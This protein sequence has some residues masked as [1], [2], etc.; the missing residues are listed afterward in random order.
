MNR[1]STNGG[2]NHGDL[3]RLSITRIFVKVSR[4]RIKFGGFNSP[5]TAGGSIHGYCSKTAFKTISET[6]LIA[7]FLLM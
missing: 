7:Q 6:F 4:E 2:L 1:L 3:M 5:K